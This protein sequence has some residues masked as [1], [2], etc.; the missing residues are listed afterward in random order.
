M[1]T[2]LP[3]HMPEKP[4][5]LI[6]DDEE[7]VRDLVAMNL[8]RAGFKTDE[9]VDGIDAVEKAQKLVPAALVLDVMMPGRDGYRVCQA[10]RD[11]PATKHIPIIMLTAK[12]QTQDRIMGLERGAD[13]YIAKPFSPKELVLR[14]QGLLRRSAMTVESA[15]ELR[16]GPFVFDVVGVK[17]HV[18][19]K[20]LDLTLIEFK[21]LHL[22]ATHKG[23]VIERD[24][25]LKNVWGYTELVRTRTLDTHVKR[26]RE[27]LGDEAEWLQTSRGYGYVFRKP[28]A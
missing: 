20:P 22:L 28:P 16:E 8:R 14:V 2:D 13:D 1:G 17:V 21:L 10:L 7:D 4:L 25:I 27:K 5:I 24:V 3:L 15:T 23:D 26:I 12:G 18:N 9:A 19:G 6:A 11:D